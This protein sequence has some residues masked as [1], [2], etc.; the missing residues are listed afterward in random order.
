M[1]EEVLAS[2]AAAAAAVTTETETAETTELPPDPAMNVD[3]FHNMINVDMSKNTGLKRLI[4]PR[5][6]GQ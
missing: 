5:P 6:D 1:K 4:S 2:A 3:N